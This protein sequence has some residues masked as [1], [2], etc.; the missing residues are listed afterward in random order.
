[1]QRRID[2]D[3]SVNIKWISFGAANRY[4]RITCYV[5]FATRRATTAMPAGATPVFRYLY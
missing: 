3:G 5:R 1:M 4:C 2:G